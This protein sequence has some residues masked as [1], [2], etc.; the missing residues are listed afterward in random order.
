M[1]MHA[2][3]ACLETSMNLHHLGHGLGQNFL[4]H[5]HFEGTLAT[6]LRDNPLI[7]GIRKLRSHVLK[8]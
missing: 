7:Y 4:N 8:N 5:T 3:V 1:H 6:A 2:I